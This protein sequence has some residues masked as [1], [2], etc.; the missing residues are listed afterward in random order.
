MENG[1]LMSPYISTE[2][3][4]RTQWL[5]RH[6]PVIGRIMIRQS[7]ITSPVTFKV[8]VYLNLNVVKLQQRVL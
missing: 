4:E 7:V 1:K 2:S 6:A 8:K 3:P 5:L